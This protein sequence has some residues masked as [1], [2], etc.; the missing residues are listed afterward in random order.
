MPQYVENKI[1]KIVNDKI[2]YATPADEAL[3]RKL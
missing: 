2:I 3:T 1:L